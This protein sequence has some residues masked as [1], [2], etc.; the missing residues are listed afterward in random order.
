VS[1]PLRSL[2]CAANGAERQATENMAWCPESDVAALAANVGFGS[3]THALEHQHAVALVLELAA[4]AH[5]DI[6]QHGA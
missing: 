3:L 5:A 6:G 2:P 1:C 4:F